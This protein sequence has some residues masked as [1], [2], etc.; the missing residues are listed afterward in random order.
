VGGVDVIMLDNMS[1]EDNETGGEADCRSM[2]D[3]SGERITR[4]R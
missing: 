2:Q 1:T 3:G 4:L